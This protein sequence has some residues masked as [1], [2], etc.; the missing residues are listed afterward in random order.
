MRVDFSFLVSRYHSPEDAIRK[1][2]TK[3]KFRAG[4]NALTPKGDSKPGG[5]LEKQFRPGALRSASRARS[6]QAEPPTLPLFSSRFVGRRAM[7][8]SLMVAAQFP[9]RALPSLACKQAVTRVV[10]ARTL[11]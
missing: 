9:G 10:A 1:G 11:P 4:R 2:E 5:T 8:N 6:G 3:G 7:G